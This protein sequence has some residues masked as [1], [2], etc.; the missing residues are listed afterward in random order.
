VARWLSDAGVHDPQTVAKNAAA[1][2]AGQYGGLNKAWFK[3]F[4]L[5]LEDPSLIDKAIANAEA[6]LTGG[7]NASTIAVVLVGLG[8]GLWFLSQRGGRA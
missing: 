8:F 6:Q 4:V 2:A 7:S 3:D 5:F 1:A